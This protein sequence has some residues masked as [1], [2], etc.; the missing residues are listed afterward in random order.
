MHLYLFNAF[1]PI[2]AKIETNFAQMN[3]PSTT[4]MQYL[5]GQS[6][7]AV[8]VAAPEPEPEV[9]VCPVCMEVP[10]PTNVAITACGHKF[11][12]SCL[13]KSLKTKNTCPTCRAEIEPEREYIEPLPVSVAS[14][15]IRTEELTIQMTRRIAV[16]NSF[17]AGRNGR[18]AM[19]SSLC[20]EVAF[21]T[22]HGIARWQK[23][24]DET[25][26]ESWDEFDSSDGE[27]D[28]DADGDN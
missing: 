7:A 2:R 6:V 13:L 25:Y 5:L 10:G 11:C 22:A 8:A 14:E 12:M 16:I 4:H 18:A 1:N 3:Q 9:D 28:S 17:S 27:S 15:L 20:R 19:I 23:L 26:H 24:S 21:A